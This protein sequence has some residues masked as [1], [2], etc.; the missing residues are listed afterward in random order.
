MNILDIQD[1][2]KGLSQ[3]QLAQ[4][5]QSPSGQVPQFLVLGEMSR[6]QAMRQSMQQ[7]NAGSQTVAQ[8][9]LS[10][11]GVPSESMSDMAQ[12]MAPKSSITQNTGIGSLPQEAPP[13]EEGGIA[14]LA[15]QEQKP[16]GMAEGGAVRKMFDG[17]QVR[18]PNRS[19]VPS[20][21][22]YSLGTNSLSR[23]GSG[24][25][26]LLS[27]D[28]RIDQEGNVSIDGPRTQDEGIGSIERP[29]GPVVMDSENLL[30]PAMPQVNTPDAPVDT[31]DG[32]VSGSGSGGTGGGGTMSTYEQMLADA[33]KNAEKTAKQDKWLALAQAGAALYSGASVGDAMN[34][35]ITALQSA[36][37]TGEQNRLK[38]AQEMYGIEQQKAAMARAAAGAGAASSRPRSST[39]ILSDIKT[40]DEILG[41]MAG[42][43]ELGQALPLDPAQQE[44]AARLRAQ[45]DALIQML[46]G[47]GASTDLSDL[48]Q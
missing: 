17:S 37:D 43:D 19:G 27:S 47:Q 34:T 12:T 38:L 29:T 36:R 32:S 25:Y 24:I 10:G 35:G 39:S 20:G 46:Q 3:D 48:V 15:A 6:R 11:A 8:E 2:L 28:V 31:G 13:P 42:T 45:Q 16:V 41:S 1:K 44:T 14:A 4:E 21:Q 5:M 23:L 22:E 26:D 40:I 7:Q 33:M 18:P 9:L 30:Y